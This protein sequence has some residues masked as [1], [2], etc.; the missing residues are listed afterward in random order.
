MHQRHIETTC[1]NSSMH[2]QIMDAEAFPGYVLFG[3][4]LLACYCV[5]AVACPDCY[6][7]G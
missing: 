5:V 1:R 7:W 2:G 3:F 4:Q 6:H